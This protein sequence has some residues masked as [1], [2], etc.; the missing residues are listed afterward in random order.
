MTQYRLR[1]AT[2]QA[3]R[4]NP[5]AEGDNTSEVLAFA[6]GHLYNANDFA[7]RFT[8]DMTVRALIRGDWA[9]KNAH[10]GMIQ[11]VTDDEFHRRFVIDDRAESPTGSPGS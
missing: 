2:V 9:V 11:A 7:I 1:H 5:T 3:I 4:W 10:T 8:S 6:R